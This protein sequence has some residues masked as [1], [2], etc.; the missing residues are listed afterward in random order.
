[1][2]TSF[3][4]AKEAALVLS[5]KRLQDSR[6]YTVQVQHINFILHLSCLSDILGVMN[7]YNC[8]IQGPRGNIVGFAIKLTT[9]GVGKVRLASQMR[10]FDPR[11]VALQFF[12]RNTEDLFLFCN[13]SYNPHFHLLRGRRPFFA[14]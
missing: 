9:S 4:V 12:V 2:E 13:C 6:G 10:L 3:C 7:H 8:Y 1:M 5:Y 11:S 14:F